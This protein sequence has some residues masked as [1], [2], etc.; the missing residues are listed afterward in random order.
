MSA[1]GGKADMP[2]FAL[3]LS[4]YDPKRTWRNRWNLPKIELGLHPW[5]GDMQRRGGS[6]QSIKG[7]RGVG[8]KSRKTP[9]KHATPAELQQK[10]TRLEC[11]LD[12]ALDRA[13]SGRRQS[14]ILLWGRPNARVKCQHVP[15]IIETEARVE[16]L[17]SVG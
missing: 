14:E 1:F 15:E 8:P 13:V 17:P 6:G 4:A 5:R 11:D 2:F 16:W 7:P 12:E 10:V 9:T 3:R